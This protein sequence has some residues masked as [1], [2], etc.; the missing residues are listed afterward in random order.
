MGRELLLR[1]SALPRRPV[2]SCGGWCASDRI[3]LQSGTYLRYICMY[4]RGLVSS[5]LVSRNK[6]SSTIPCARNSTGAS[7]PNT[8]NKQVPPYECAIRV[9]N[10]SHFL[11]GFFSARIMA[12][13]TSQRVAA[14]GTP[15]TSGCPLYRWQIKSGRQ[16]ASL[17]THRLLEACVLCVPAVTLQTHIPGNFLWLYWASCNNP[18]PPVSTLARQF[19]ADIRMRLPYKKKSFIA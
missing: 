13:S 14:R 3:A 10:V 17:A 7:S 8:S 16:L 15:R 11:R 2:Q 1:V 18:R 6:P 19:L 5:C 9:A 4:C 12:S